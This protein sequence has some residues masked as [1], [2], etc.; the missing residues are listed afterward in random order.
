MP[1]TLKTALRALGHRN[2]RLFFGGQAVSLIGTW[3]TRLASS[4]L[5]YRLT[6]DPAMLGI[7]NFASLAPSFLLGPFAGVWVDRSKSLQRLIFVTQF[8]GMLQSVGLVLVAAIPAQ[9]ATT[10][11]VLIAL[12]VLQGVINAFDMPARQ[13]FLPRMVTERNDL[14]NGIALNS[15]LFNAARLIGPALAGALIA[16]VGEAW[17]FGI[18]ALSYVGVLWAVRAMRVNEEG[19]RPKEGQRMFASLIE[20]LRYAWDSEPIRAIL[21]LIAALSFLGLPYTVLLPIYAKEILGGGPKT[22]GWLTA[23]AG[24]GALIAAL[25]LARRESIAGIGRVIVV[26]G[27]LFSAALLGFAYSRSLTLSGLLLLGTGFGMLTQSASCNTIIQSIVEPDKRGRV[28]S[29]YLMAFVGIA[30]F[31]GLTAGFFARRIGAPATLAG[32][33]ALGALSTL[34]FA[35]KLPRLREAVRERL[36]ES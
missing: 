15:S 8:A 5:V 36:K 23:A 18:D 22:L 4:W 16:A 21:I 2:Y 17:C 9:P 30:P 24:L 31:G 19:F 25:R 10:V 7:V 11:G 33:A 13:A 26:A 12:N 28:M 34:R 14:A 3:M 35:T 29:L 6:S 20:G 1:P 32:C 27:A